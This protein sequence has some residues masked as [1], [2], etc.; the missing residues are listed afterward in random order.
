MALVVSAQ[1]RL[2]REAISWPVSQEGAAET[3]EEREEE[4]EGFI[5]IEI[6]KFLR[7]ISNVCLALKSIRALLGNT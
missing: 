1:K 5:Y 3:E 7:S 6:S 4:P 2:G